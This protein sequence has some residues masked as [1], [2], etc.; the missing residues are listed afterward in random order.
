MDQRKKKGFG[1]GACCLT[2]KKEREEDEKENMTSFY[3]TVRTEAWSLAWE[4][5]FIDCSALCCAR[6]LKSAGR[7]D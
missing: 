3:I 6:W 7:V 4:G 1:F 2:E 5:F